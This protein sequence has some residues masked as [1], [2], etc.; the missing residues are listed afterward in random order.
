MNTFQR[1]LMSNW[2]GNM[3]II[4]LNF[5]LL[6]SFFER[7]RMKQSVSV[8][9]GK[10][11]SFFFSQRSTWNRMDLLFLF[12]IMYVE[13]LFYSH[14]IFKQYFEKWFSNE[15]NDC[16]IFIFLRQIIIASHCSFLFKRNEIYKYVNFKICIY[17]II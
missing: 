2:E 13:C 11:L 1:E 12:I 17:Y 14:W 10:C 3:L 7:K 15:T 8:P 4:I 9:C 16:L 5:S 6:T